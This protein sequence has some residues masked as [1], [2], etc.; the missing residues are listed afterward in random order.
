[1][2]DFYIIEDHARTPLT[3]D[4]LEAMWAGALDERTFYNL[5]QKGVIGGRYDY[6]IDFRWDTDVVL[7]IQQKIKIGGIEY[8]TDVQ[9][10]V[11]VLDA[12]EKQRS[13]LMAFAD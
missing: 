5:R 7:Q 8:D 13:G 6:H 3:P 1:M 10:L 11:V 9:R 4:Q 12:A 2:L